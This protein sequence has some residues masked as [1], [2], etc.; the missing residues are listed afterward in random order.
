MLR[1]NL[2][3]VISSFSKDDRGTTAIEYGMLGV[4]IALAVLTTIQLLGTTVLTEF[5][6]QIAAAFAV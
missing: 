3:S 6:Q 1:R 5:Y 4:F 2:L